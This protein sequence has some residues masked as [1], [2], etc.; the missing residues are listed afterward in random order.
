LSAPEWLRRLVAEQAHGY[1]FP[2][3]PAYARFEPDVG[4]YGVLV[5]QPDLSPLGN[6]ETVRFMAP[7]L[8]AGPL[9]GYMRYT[10]AAGGYIDPETGASR[11]A[12]GDG[13]DLEEPDEAADPAEDAKEW[14]WPDD[15]RGPVS[16]DG[17]NPAFAGRRIRE[18]FID[19]LGWRLILERRD[20]SEPW[21][22][23]LEEPTAY[24]DVFDMRL[25]SAGV[26]RALDPERVAGARIEAVAVAGGRLVLTLSSG[27][28]LESPPDTDYE[29]WQLCAA[30]RALW[31]CLPGG[32]VGMFALGDASA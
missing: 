1:G 11:F 5:A 7:G 15:A 16:L 32:R 6:A 19:H 4:G 9:G 28:A 12:E 2:P 21:V 20:W 13:E 8:S 17:V 29:S 23:V 25:A 30:G 18:L 14:S 22:E 3:P 24:I 31:V 27:D 10:D 26:E